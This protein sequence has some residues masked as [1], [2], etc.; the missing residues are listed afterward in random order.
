MRCN[1]PPT[2]PVFAGEGRRGKG[3]GVRLKKEGRGQGEWEEMTGLFL[4]YSV[5]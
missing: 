5:V 3:F 4:W 2:C 1:R